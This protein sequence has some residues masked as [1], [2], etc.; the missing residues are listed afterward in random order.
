[1]GDACV[2]DVDVGKVMV[3]DGLRVRKTRGS[4]MDDFERSYELR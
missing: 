3:D 1:M 2:M 4:K